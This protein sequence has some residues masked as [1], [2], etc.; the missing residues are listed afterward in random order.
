MIHAARHDA[1]TPAADYYAATL[2][3]LP[4]HT[5]LS[6]CAAMPLFYAPRR[7]VFALFAAYDYYAAA[8]MMPLQPR[9][10]FRQRSY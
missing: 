6:C 4:R 5:L 9:R 10:F 8:A 1:A 7:A 3:L 2:T